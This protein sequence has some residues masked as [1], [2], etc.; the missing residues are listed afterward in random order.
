MLDLAHCLVISPFV[1][2]II[3]LY[4]FF[5]DKLASN[6]KINM[7]RGVLIYSKPCIL[8]VLFAVCHLYSQTQAIIYKIAAI[9]DLDAILNSKK[10][11]R[12]TNE[13]F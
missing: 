8:T 6:H 12:R 2:P 4:D 5:W 1:C 9:L 7:L 11:S 3:P 13:D 10:N